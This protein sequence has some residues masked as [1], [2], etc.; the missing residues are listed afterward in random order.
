MLVW[1]SLPDPRSDFEFV[2]ACM[3]EGRI[4]TR[5]ARRRCDAHSANALANAVG[6]SRTSCSEVYTAIEFARD[7]YTALP[8]T[9][10]QGQFRRERTSTPR[11]DAR[12]PNTADSDVWGS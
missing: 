7:E 4:V 6:T 12:R 9:R 5:P 3:S 2:M 11:D 8:K 10:S 1:S